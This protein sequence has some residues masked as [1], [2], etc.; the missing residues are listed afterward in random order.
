MERPA[1]TSVWK[2]LEL[3]NGKRRVFWCARLWTGEITKHKTH[4]A[5][6]AAYWA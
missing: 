6:V 1:M 5:A 2:M 4:K 3:A